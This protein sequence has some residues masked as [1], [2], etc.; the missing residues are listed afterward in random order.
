VP[1][2]HEI[3]Y[4]ETR[5]FAGCAL[6]N[7]ANAGR[8]AVKTIAWTKHTAWEEYARER[9]PSFL[10]SLAEARQQVAQ[11]KTLSHHELKRTLGID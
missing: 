8:I 1:E 5:V 7:P 4:A 6:K 2:P 3:R 11:G 10:A 9:A